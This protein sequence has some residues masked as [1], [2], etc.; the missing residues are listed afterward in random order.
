MA[1]YEQVNM[2]SQI[3]L[4]H[5]FICEVFQSYIQWS[6]AQSICA[7]TATILPTAESTLNG[8]NYFGHI[9]YM[10]HLAYTKLQ[11]NLLH[12]LVI[13]FIFIF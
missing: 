10:P 2:N 3:R 13:Q 12:T 6:N 7:P 11:Q 1:N 4:C 5:T 8:L 9:K